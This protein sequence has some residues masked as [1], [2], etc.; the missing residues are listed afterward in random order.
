MHMLKTAIKTFL[1]VIFLTATATAQQ[2][3][4]DVRSLLEERDEQ[5]KE[6]VGPEGTEYTDEQRQQLKEII[7]GVINFEAMAK[8]ALEETYDTIAT[9]KRTEFVDLFATIVRDQSLNKLD[10]YRAKVTYRDIQVEGD[11]AR[12]E[13]LA[14]LENVRTPVNYEM[15]YQDGRW[16]IVDMEIDDVS[17]ASS[18]N[19]QF[20]R[21]INQKGFEPLLESLRKRA[22]RA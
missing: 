6:L 9:E 1:L 12:V 5:I 15:E 20:Q 11:E 2:T 21:I 7:N 16:V 17:T 22:A 4:E 8:E 10:I 18:Y 19:R 3:A 13:T 14:Q